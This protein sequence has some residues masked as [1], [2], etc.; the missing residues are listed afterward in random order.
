MKKEKR[1]CNAFVEK[2]NARCENY[3]L[4][5]T[6]YCFSHYPKK[7]PIVLSLLLSLLTFILTILFNEPLTN[8]LSKTFHYLDDDLPTIK[9]MNPNIDKSMELDKNTKLFKI[10]CFDKGS[11]LDLPKC[12]INI[13]DRKDGKR[14]L[15]VG[16][17]NKSD[18]ELSFILDTNL[19]NGEYDFEAFLIDKAGN[20]TDLILP[21]I[22]RENEALQCTASYAKYE[23]SQVKETFRSFI[24]E[25]KNP[26]LQTKDYYVYYLEFANKDNNV[27]LK[28]L[29]FYIQ[30]R[31]GIIWSW[32]KVQ[33]RN[34]EGV[35]V[36][37]PW[38]QGLPRSQNQVFMD[39]GVIYIDKIGVEGFITV[40]ILIDRTELS[41]GVSP[42][43]IELWGKYF[44]EGYGTSKIH[45]F[46]E[47]ALNI[48]KGDLNF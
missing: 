30:T 20:K 5:G 14:K 43:A 19:K 40:A 37:L 48:N 3:V 44:S 24:E 32:K 46:E 16:K 38:G 31:G 45:E 28:N 27:I 22:V 13:N 4:G 35:E 29:F 47:R 39:S 23:E 2:N 8:R 17:L 11:G 7:E 34:A 12:L 36:T 33:N 18:R 6:N 26:F 21:F 41:G 25:H 15:I 10:I 1:K 9:V 42:H